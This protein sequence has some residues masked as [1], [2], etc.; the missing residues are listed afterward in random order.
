M[1]ADKTQELLLDLHVYQL[2][3]L[4]HKFL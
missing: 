1:F 2:H 4:V 3:I